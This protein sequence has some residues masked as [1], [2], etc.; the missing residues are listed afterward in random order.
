M[1]ITKAHRLWTFELEER[2]AHESE[3]EP[4]FAPRKRTHTVELDH[5]HITMKRTIK[6]DGDILPPSEIRSYGVPSMS[7]DDLFRVDGHDCIVQTRIKGINYAYDLAIDGI[8]MQTGFPAEIHPEVYSV[9]KGTKD[10]MPTWV[11]LYF[12]VSFVLGIGAGIGGAALGLAI[13]QTR[14]PDREMLK[15]AGYFSMGILMQ[16][17]YAIATASKNPEKNN[18]GRMIHCAL[19]AGRTIAIMFAIFLGTVILFH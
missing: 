5:S 9:S 13:T 15:I 3:G 17:L 4:V 7:S 8:S 18:Q 6:L 1:E 14:T 12:V 19:L 16:G 10:R 11:W 2:P